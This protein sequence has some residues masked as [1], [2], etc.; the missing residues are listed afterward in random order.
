MHDKFPAKVKNVLAYRVSLQCSNPECQ[1]PTSAAHNRPDKYNVLGE[2]AHITGARPR[3]PRYD[4][5]LT[6]EERRA[7]TNGVW[8]CRLCARVIDT[9]V[10]RFPATMLRQWKADAER[11][12]LEELKIVAQSETPDSVQLEECDLV[13]DVN[14][15]FGFSFLAPANWNYWVPEN[16]DGSKFAHPDDERIEIRAWGGYAVL[17]DDL[18]SSVEFEI[19]CFRRNVLFELVSMTD[20]T[21]SV[22]DLEGNH[23][24]QQ[25]VKAKRLVYRNQTHTV[26]QV[27]T[28]VGGTEFTIRCQAPTERFPEFRTMFIH[29]THGFQILGPTMAEHAQNIPL[30][31]DTPDF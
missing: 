31:Q 22:C 8:L 9:D 26:L 20:V 21:R 16:S 3:G 29:A 11:G 15:R 25:R 7:A 4:P 24:V 10:E 13:R 19:D 6:Q 27:K 14:V 12:L 28:R 30:T 17:H 2:A 23:L 18:E 5:T 1:R